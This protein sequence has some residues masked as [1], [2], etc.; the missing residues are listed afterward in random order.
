[1][2]YSESY[3][4]G[5][6]IKAEA[7]IV[8]KSFSATSTESGDEVNG[9]VI[10]RQAL[11]RHYYSARAVVHGRLTGSTDVKATLAMNVQHSSSTGSTSFSDWSTGTESTAVTI[12]STASTAA[13]AVDGEIEQC[14]N[15]QGAKRYLRVQYT[16]T[17]SGTTAGTSM[18]VGGVIVFG[19]A[20]EL[21]SS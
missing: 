13:Q 7:A 9:V 14:F 4:I 15:L 20:D 11:P 18:A 2:S 6:Y 8:G 3:N 17:L 19:G 5:K 16:P 12:G 10:D 21:P 1:M